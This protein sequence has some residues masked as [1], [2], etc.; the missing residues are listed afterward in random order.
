MEYEVKLPILG[1]E[2]TT[3]VKFE[4][5]DDFSAKITDLDN[6]NISF[7]LINPYALMEYS[8]DVPT[9]MQVL[10]EINENSKIN[11][12]NILILQ[13]PVK[14][15]VVNFLAPVVFNEDNKTMGQAV[16]PI[17]EYPEF[18]NVRE[19]GEFIKEEKLAS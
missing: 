15:S 12:Y 18:S 6:P 14:K 19:I 7:M 11:V 8:F 17:R 10:L 5:I 2:E 9:P 1:F 3:R 4:K 13:K 16:L